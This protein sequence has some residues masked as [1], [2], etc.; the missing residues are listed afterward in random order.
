MFGK[1]GAMLG[2][3]S[4][5]ARALEQAAP[6]GNVDMSYCRL[7]REEAARKRKAKKANKA[8]K[9]ARRRNRR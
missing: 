2:I 9:K 8:A 7:T 3:A 6:A 5:G 1:L 4:S